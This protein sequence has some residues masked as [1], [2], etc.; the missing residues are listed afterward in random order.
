MSAAWRADFGSDKAD[1][2]AAA[3][4][5]RAAVEVSFSIFGCCCCSGCDS[6][7]AL[8]GLALPDMDGSAWL[9]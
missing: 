5:L 1:K 7:Y 6:V 2:Q 3:Q 4:A 8:R 9:H